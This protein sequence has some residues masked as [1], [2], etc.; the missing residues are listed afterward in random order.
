MHQRADDDLMR[1]L[2]VILALTCVSLSLLFLGP[3]L[4]APFAVSAGLLGAAV[5]LF[6]VGRP[7][8]VLR[9]IVVDGSN[10]MYW[11]DETPSLHTVRSVVAALR[12]EGLHPVV[13]FDANAGYL[14][15]G[16]YLGSD[17]LSRLI[18]LP[19]RQVF[20]AEKG[21]PA[22]PLILEGAGKLGARVVTNDR[23]RDWTERFP[24]VAEPGFLVRGQ[25]VGGEVRLRLGEPATVA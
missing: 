11:E 14:T 7:R 18:G 9:W 10:V 16:R 25:V 2:L 8:K 15:M 22:D 4:S 24:K 19:G 23:Y 12:D 6:V 20:I 21:V 5:F 13:W 1:L 17:A 3:A